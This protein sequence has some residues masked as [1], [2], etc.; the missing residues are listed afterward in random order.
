MMNL[1]MHSYYLAQDKSRKQN[2]NIKNSID[3]KTVKGSLNYSNQVKGQPNNTV[4][5]NRSK[6]LNSKPKK[7]QALK[8]INQLS[9]NLLVSKEKLLDKLNE[10]E[11]V[12]NKYVSKK[13]NKYNPQLMQQAKNDYKAISANYKE[14]VNGTLVAKSKDGKAIPGMTKQLLMKIV[15]QSTLS[16]ENSNSNGVRVNTK[17]MK[18]RKLN[19]LAGKADNGS[20]QVINWSGDV[21]I[22]E[23]NSNF[24]GQ[25]SFGRVQRVANIS[26]A[27]VNALK[28]SC[29]KEEKNKQLARDDIKNEYSK[30]TEIHENGLQ[31]GLQFPPSTNYEI[32]NGDDTEI[33]MLQPIYSEGELFDYIVDGT[34]DNLTPK[35]RIQL[36]VKLFKGL[37]TLQEQNIVHGDIK[38]ENCFVGIKD[39]NV[40]IHI[41]DLG[42]AKNTKTELLLNQP[43]NLSNFNLNS[44]N[45]LGTIATPGYFTKTDWNK[46]YQHAFFKDQKSWE[47]VQMKRDVF[48]TAT[49][50]YALLTKNLPYG[51]QSNNPNLV[52][53]SGI[54]FDEIMNMDTVYGEEITKTLL[55][56]LDEDPEKRPNIDS[57]INALE[58]SV[59]TL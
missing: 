52:D 59:V 7:S 4:A 38:L 8:D 27:E 25:G 16:L 28:I 47:N 2:K 51:F 14:G 26:L 34:I 15:R 44:G 20:L 1:G 22:N 17:S 56:A 54:D 32:S 21:N 35:K 11:N 19:L 42:G 50:A 6:K 37:N 30:L 57:I 58:T 3:P 29:P 31:E 13:K 49:V 18:Q 39:G 43:D 55:A 53:T 10:G 23:S 36:L 24:L 46:S 41:A 40:F 33:G 48:A 9:Q 12:F 5:F 45:A